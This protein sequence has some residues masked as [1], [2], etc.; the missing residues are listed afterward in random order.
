MLTKRRRIKGGDCNNNYSDS[1]S[2]TEYTSGNMANQIHRILGDNNNQSNILTPISQNYN[3][4]QF[5]FFGG[6]NKKST[7]RKKRK[8]GFVGEVINQAI[9]PFSLLA[10]SQSFSGSKKLRKKRRSKRRR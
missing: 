8:G 7:R 9:V 5:K 1:S 3:N 6:K 10:L 2:Y 4:G